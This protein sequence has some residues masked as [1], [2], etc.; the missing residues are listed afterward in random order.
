MQE[1][2]SNEMLIDV[3]RHEPLVDWGQLSEDQLACLLRE[4][5]INSSGMDKAVLMRNC[6]IYKDLSE[7]LHTT[8]YVFWSVF[9]NNCILI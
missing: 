7:F 1:E 6:E 9:E 2:A 5:G 8:I 3:E 4:I